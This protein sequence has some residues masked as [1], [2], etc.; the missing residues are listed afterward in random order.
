MN[1]SCALHSLPAARE[2]QTPKNKKP[3]MEPQIHADKTRESVKAL[4]EC[5]LSP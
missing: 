2:R 4:S 5:S 3:S 1:S